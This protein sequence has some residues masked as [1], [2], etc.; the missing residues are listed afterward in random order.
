MSL[1]FWL[2]VVAAVAVV[3]YLA[4]CALRKRWDRA[5]KF[6]RDSDELVKHRESILVCLRCVYNDA[7]AVVKCMLRAIDCATS[8]LRLRFA[9]VQEAAPVDVY[10]LFE[11]KQNEPSDPA[12]NFA[13]KIA[14]SNLIHSD[15]YLHAFGEWQKLAVDEQ[16]VVCMDARNQ[17]MQGWDCALVDSLHRTAS[18]T[19]LTAPNALEF[20]V[21]VRA[22]PHQHLWPVVVGR[23]FAY[24]PKQST[25]AIA[26]HHNFVALHGEFFR[27]LPFPTTFT[28]LYVA[29]VVLTDHLLNQ[30]ALLKT[31]A[32]K[33]FERPLAVHS[34]HL[35]SQRPQRWDRTLR[36][37]VLASAHLGARLPETDEASPTPAYFEILP[38]AFLGLTENA[39]K[40]S[41]GVI[42]YGT[43]RE[44]ERQL[45]LANYYR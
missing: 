31:L 3:G 16:Y 36:L 19:V 40:T 34:A 12:H 15:G 24:P 13:A 10:D 44:V 21:L 25:A 8:P 43:K 6:R 11:Q 33:L 23:K 41:E 45:V 27:S 22:P 7:P 14:T 42:K 9:V 35:D 2:I 30:S 4:Y 38:R 26:V 29:D 17:M 18:K 32:V 5:A 20:P 39:L 28:P 37:S 1:W